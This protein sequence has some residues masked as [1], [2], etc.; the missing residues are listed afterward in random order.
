[1]GRDGRSVVE[2]EARLKGSVNDVNLARDL[3]DSAPETGRVSLARRKK[4]KVPEKPNPTPQAAISSSSSSSKSPSG[5]GKVKKREKTK[6][7]GAKIDD[8]K[9]RKKKDPGAARSETATGTSSFGD[10]DPSEGPL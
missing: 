8:A 10:Y 4:P 9:N 5:G 1:M 7:R 2:I 3:E 6:R